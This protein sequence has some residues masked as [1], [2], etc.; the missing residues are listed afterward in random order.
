VHFTE[1]VFPFITGGIAMPVSGVLLKMLI[2][3]FVLYI[4]YVAL[5]PLFGL[6]SLRII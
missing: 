2:N 4:A 1:A 6:V 3:K 5:I